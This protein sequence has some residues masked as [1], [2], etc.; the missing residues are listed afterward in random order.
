LDGTDPSVY[1]APSAPELLSPAQEEQV[2]SLTPELVVT[3]ATDIDGDA[4]I[5]TFELYSDEGLTALITSTTEQPE[6][7]DGTTAWTV[8]VELAENSRYFWR[9]RANDGALDGPWSERGLF[10]VNAENSP[11]TVPN[12]LLPNGSA[13]T[14]EPVATVDPSADPDGDPISYLFQVATTDDFAEPVAE[15]ESE[16]TSWT[17]SPA[18]AG[19][20]QYWWRAAARDDQGAQSDWSGALLFKINLDNKLPSAPVII[21]PVDGST[22]NVTTVA[23]TWNQSSDE[24]GDTLT[25]E[26]Q[27]SDKADFS[28]TFFNAGSLPAGGEDTVEVQLENLTEDTTFYARVRANDG[29][30]FGEYGTVEFTVN[31]AN[32]VATAPVLV[33]PIDGATVEDEVEF[34]FTNA[35]DPDGDALSYRLE[36]ATDEQF[37]NT[38]AT[39]SDIPEGEG[40]Q[41]TVKVSASSSEEEGEAILTVGGKLYW[42]VTAV[43]ARGLDGLSSSTEDFEVIVKIGGQVAGGS[44]CNCATPNAPA[45]LPWVPA[46][47]LGAVLGLALV[48]RRR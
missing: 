28:T 41:T 1:N 22:V 38:I 11:P 36:V 18:L 16:T 35:T 13:D 48:R 40:E 7:Q 5:Y 15:G 25:Y 23:L 30:G 39:L 4:L 3:N 20:G 12:P 37:A 24:D 8:D 42:R 47:A 2:D 46:L 45:R 31:A 43:D 34:V 19:D 17:V 32:T 10:Y 27:V 26:V 6:G 29:Q 33:S 14:L 21:N 9:V 44:G